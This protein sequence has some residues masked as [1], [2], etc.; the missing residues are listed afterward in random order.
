MLILII[1]KGFKMIN[2]LRRITAEKIA[3]LELN[4]LLQELRTKLAAQKNTLKSTTA[5]SSPAIKAPIMASKPLN[6]TILK[7]T[8]FPQTQNQVQP[9]D[10]EPLLQ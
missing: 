5:K 1:S 7:Q 6:E 8:L 4:I 3:C 2:E 9:I 10:A